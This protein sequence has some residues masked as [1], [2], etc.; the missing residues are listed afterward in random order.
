MST[1][2]KVYEEILDQIKHFIKENKLSPGDRLPSERELSEQLQAGR[3]S[4]REAL[5]ALELLGLIETRRGE[6]TFL[7]P[8]RTYHTV[9]LLSAFILQE[10]KTRKDILSCKAIVEKEAAKLAYSKMNEGVIEELESVYSN[11][12]LDPKKRYEQF[13]IIIFK[14]AD[15]YLLETIWKLLYDFSS[16]MEET[17]YYNQSFYIEI[18][19]AYKKKQF[20]SIEAQF[21]N[22]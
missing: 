7:K 12:G 2:S 20:V 6:G 4:V 16:T 15:N 5:R 21:M 11:N 17:N 13:F 9:E 3:S 14:K 8:Y 10:T 1:K 18:L 19:Q 22:N